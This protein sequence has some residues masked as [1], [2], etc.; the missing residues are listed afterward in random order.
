MLLYVGGLVVVYAKWWAWYGGISWGPRFFVFAAIPASLL[1]AVRICSS[2]ASAVADAVTLGVLSLSA[3]V[4]VVGLTVDLSTLSVCA[5]SNYA[6]ES[7]CWYVPEYSG[8]WQPF[9]H[10]PPRTWETF[11]ILAWC[12]AIYLRLAFPLVRGLVGAQP[13]RGIDRGWARTWRF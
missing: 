10:A 7:F 5:R 1:I 3:W 12:L 9:I 4:G 2:G 8:L 13:L 6:V 11:V